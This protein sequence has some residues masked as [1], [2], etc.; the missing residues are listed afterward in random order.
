MDNATETTTATEALEAWELETYGAE[1]EY[2]DADSPWLELVAD[3]SVRE[4][5]YSFGSCDERI[6]RSTE[7]DALVAEGYRLRLVAE[8]DARIEAAWQAHLA[9]DA[10]VEPF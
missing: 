1:G 9:A 3:G 5:Y 4:F 10:D 7:A 8:N 6:M 2:A